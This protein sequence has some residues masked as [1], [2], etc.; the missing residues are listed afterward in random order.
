MTSYG[1]EGTRYKRDDTKLDWS[2]GGMDFPDI[3]TSWKA[4]KF[5][6]LRRMMTTKGTWV[7]VLRDSLQPKFI[8]KNL[9]SAM[10]NLDLIQLSRSSKHIRNAFWREI[11]KTIPEMITS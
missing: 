4:F 10:A 1:K 3:K 8:F 9:Q 7:E 6:W 5:S 11:F 2:K